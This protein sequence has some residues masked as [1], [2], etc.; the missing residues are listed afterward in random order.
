MVLRVPV[1]LVLPKS[2]WHRGF[3]AESAVV[4]QKK[5]MSGL[6]LGLEQRSST[7]FRSMS[8]R[9]VKPKVQIEETPGDYG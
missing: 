7:L 5:G 2:L 8:F 3:L 6:N 9:A 1:P 4:E